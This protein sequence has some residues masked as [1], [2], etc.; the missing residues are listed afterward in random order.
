MKKHRRRTKPQK[1]LFRVDANSILT[2]QNTLSI[3]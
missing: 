3:V 2:N 1:V